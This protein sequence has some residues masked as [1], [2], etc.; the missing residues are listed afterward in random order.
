MDRLEFAR[1]IKSNPAWKNLSEE[2]ENYGSSA[3]DFAES[4]FEELDDG[5]KSCEI[6]LSSG[7]MLTITEYGGIYPHFRF[8]W[9]CNADGYELH[10]LPFSTIFDGVEHLIGVVGGEDGEILWRWFCNEQ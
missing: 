9:M 5:R 8:K 1:M 7:G 6:Q 3:I 4:L 10:S 2:I